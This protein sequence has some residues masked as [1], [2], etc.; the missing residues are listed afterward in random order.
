ME[1]TQYPL[2][3]LATPKPKNYLIENIVASVVGIACCCGVNLIPGIIGIVFSTQVDS[4]YNVGDYT[5]AA[6][7]A[8]TAKILF[9]VTA[10]LVVLGLLINLAYFFFFGAA[11]FTGLRERG[12][13]NF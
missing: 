11:L 1:P 9:Y 2:N 12:F 5:G 4:K 7:A 3:P 8:N 13:D 6:S 10:G